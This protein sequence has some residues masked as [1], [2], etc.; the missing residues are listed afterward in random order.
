MADKTAI[1]WTDAT[2]NP[3]TGCSVVSSGC[4]NCYAQDLAATRLRNHPS[5]KGLTNEHGKWNGQ[6]RLNE[7]WLEQPIR[8]KRPRRIFVCAH[9]DLFHEAVPIEWQMRVFEVMRRAPQHVYQVLTKRATHMFYICHQSTM[10]GGEWG[11]QPRP[12][13]W[14][15]VSVETQAEMG[16]AYTLGM[17][18]AGRRFVSAEPLLGA[19]D[20]T[21]HERDP[22]NP[23]MFPN[24]ELV[25]NLLTGRHA[26]GRKFQE[27]GLDWIIVGGESGTRARPMHPEW[28]TSIR[29]QCAAAG[30]PFFFK[31]W[32]EWSPMPVGTLTGFPVEGPPPHGFVGLDGK[33]SDLWLKRGDWPVERVGKKR[34]GRMLEGREYG[35]MPGPLPRPSPEERAAAVSAVEKAFAA[36]TKA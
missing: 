27:R 20:F 7:G 4:T 16:R 33:R 13:I 24:R 36:G 10:R 12:N 25:V 17:T 30:V 11:Y 1:E 22:L 21:R 15:G 26:D 28:A 8:W 23:R 2:W 9:G 19:L 35:E 6:V 32:G 14:L 31:Q 3:I 34:A 5:R 18:P 29:D